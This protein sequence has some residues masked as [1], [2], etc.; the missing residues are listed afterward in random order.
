MREFIKF[1]IFLFLIAWLFAISFYCAISDSMVKM[2]LQENHELK[3]TVATLQ[4][5]LTILENK[6]KV[7]EQQIPTIEIKP[8]TISFDPTKMSK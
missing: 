6:V 2:L 8:P 1:F 3:R 7:Q 4:N 5:N